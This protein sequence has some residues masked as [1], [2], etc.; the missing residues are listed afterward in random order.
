MHAWHLFPIRLRLESLAVDRNEFVEDL[1]RE[2]IGT[3]VHW[4]PLHFHPYYEETYGWTRSD[5]PD[6]SRVWERLVSLPLFP[7]LRDDEQDRVVAVIRALCRRATA[8]PAPVAA[9]Q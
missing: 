8:F 5:F 9:T 1:K 3:S 2:G 7:D 4:R 6:A